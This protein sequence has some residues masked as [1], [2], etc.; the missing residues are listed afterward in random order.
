MTPFYAIWAWT[1]E[2]QVSLGV[3]GFIFWAGGGTLWLRMRGTVHPDTNKGGGHDLD[4]PWAI[5]GKDDPLLCYLS[6]DQGKSG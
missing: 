3:F 5:L 6:M 1:K 4:I 2:N